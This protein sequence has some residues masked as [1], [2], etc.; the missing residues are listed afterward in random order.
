MKNILTSLLL[1]SAVFSI[2]IDEATGWEYDQSTLQAFY[3]LEVLTVDG[4]IA[5]EEDVVGAERLE[6]EVRR[7]ERDLRRERVLRRERER[8]FLRPA[9]EP[10]LA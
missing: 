6:P 2:T 8:L 7:R 1:I 5:E 4:E 3:M 10:A 9:P